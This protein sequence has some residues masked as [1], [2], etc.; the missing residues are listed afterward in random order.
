[1]NK[2]IF[3]NMNDACEKQIHLLGGKKKAV[4]KSSFKQV[5][6]SQWGMWETGQFANL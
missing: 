1:M 5:S 6:N 4:T 3:L 2:Q